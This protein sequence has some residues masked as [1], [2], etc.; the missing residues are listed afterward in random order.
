VRF[1]LGALAA[2]LIATQANAQQGNGVIAGGL[3]G[4]TVALTPPCVTTPSSLQ[5]DAAGVFGCI[6]GA[7]SDGTNLT[8]GATN[9]RVLGS[10]T[11]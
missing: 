10:S 4:F 1:I 6:S 3:G 8:L 11:G 2:L 9:F 5:Y 7:T